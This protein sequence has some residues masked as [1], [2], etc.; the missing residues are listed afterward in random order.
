MLRGLEG[1]FYNQTTAPLSPIKS[2][3]QQYRKKVLSTPRTSLY[4]PKTLSPGCSK[5]G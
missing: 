3:T 4:K 2:T 1:V 5:D